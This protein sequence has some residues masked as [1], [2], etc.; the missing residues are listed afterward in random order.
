MSRKPRRRS[1][2]SLAFALEPLEARWV[3]AASL[4][5]TGPSDVV[6]EGQQA[7]LTLTLS[8][9]SRLPE[10]VE[11]RTTAASATQGYDYIHHT[12]RVTFFPGETSKTISISTLRDAGVELVE[13]I[14]TFQ[15]I[16]TPV[17]S[18][19]GTRTA[20]IRV[21]DYI[22]PPYISVDDVEVTEGNDGT[23][24][25]VFTV[26][27]SQPHILPVSVNWAT[28][29]GTATTAD[30]DYVA[31]AGTLNFAPGET[32]TTVSIDVV[33]DTNKEYDETFSFVLSSPVNAL[34]QSNGTG[35]IINDDGEP[36]VELPGFQITMS[37]DDSVPPDI[38]A[39]FEEA[40]ARWE[41]VIVGDLPGVQLGPEDGDL[42]IDD[43]LIFASVTDLRIP[44]GQG[45]IAQAGP[46]NFR[47]GN[48][49]EFADDLATL[50]LPFRGVMEFSSEYTDEDIDPRNP[51]PGLVNTIAHEMGHVLGFGTLWSIPSSPYE[52]LVNGM[53]TPNPTYVGENALRE[54]KEIFQNNATS[55]PLFEV[56][57]SGEYPPPPDDGSYGS[58]WRDSVFTKFAPFGSGRIYDYTELMTAQYDVR[59]TLPNGDPIPAYLSRITVGAMEDLGYVVNYDAADDYTAPGNAAQVASLEASPP[60]ADSEASRVSPLLPQA[61]ESTPVSPSVIGPTFAV[62]RS[63]TPVARKLP[64][65]LTFPDRAPIILVDELREAVAT[66]LSTT[67]GPIN[68]RGISEGQRSMLFAWAAYGKATAPDLLS[69]IASESSD[70]RRTTHGPIA[71]S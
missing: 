29:D 51:A 60:A 11:I 28:R 56:S 61:V 17:N 64:T 47:K 5:L 40:A 67:D 33:G 3:M 7:Q 18:A 58:H 9:R 32:T 14:E 59:S 66:S 48:T 21:A 38:Q 63:Q 54:Y 49:G 62:M 31:G 57:R 6:Y 39:M 36:P 25:A 46:T 34:I 42:F 69:A 8:E 55:I 30:S 26:S 70:T 1:P 2:K 68:L 12:R 50:G 43:V 10:A 65:R 13:G 19:L 37:F 44:G 52:I 15:V 24:A 53:G 20:T 45:P 27:L 22:P 35:T 23:T 16:A 41:R 4:S 71:V